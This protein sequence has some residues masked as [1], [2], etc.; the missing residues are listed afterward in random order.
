[1]PALPENSPLLKVLM[2]VIVAGLVSLALAFGVDFWDPS[3]RTPREVS[4][5]LNVPVLAAI[6]QEKSLH[7]GRFG[8]SQPGASEAA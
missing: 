3:F 4:A 2:G 5:Y 1:V 7:D 6:P 8:P